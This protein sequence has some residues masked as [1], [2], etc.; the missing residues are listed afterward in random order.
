MGMKIKSR[1]NLFNRLNDIR[2][3]LLI[4]WEM[5]LQNDVGNLILSIRVKYK[6]F[7]KIGETS[8]NVWITDK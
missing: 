1:E 3:T 4:E 2:T 6:D 8:L 7:Q 5:I